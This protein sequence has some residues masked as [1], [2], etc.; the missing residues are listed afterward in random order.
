VIRDWIGAHQHQR[1][2]NEHFAGTQ[3]VRRSSSRT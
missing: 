1:A 3:D 2:R